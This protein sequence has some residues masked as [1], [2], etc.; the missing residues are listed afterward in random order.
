MRRSVLLTTFDFFSKPPAT[1][2]AFVLKVRHG[3]CL[4]VIPRR[5]E[6]GFVTHVG[7]VRAGEPW[8]QGG[9]TFAEMLHG[10]VEGDVRQVHSENLFA[11][12]NVR[13]IDGDLTIEMTRAEQRT[14]QNIRSVRARQDDDAL[15]GAETV[16]LDEELIQR[17]FCGFVAIG[18]PASTALTTD[19]VDLIDEYDGWFLLTR[20][21]KQIAHARRT[22]ADEHLHEIGTGDGEKRNASF[23][24]RRL[25]EQ[26]LPGS[27]RSDEEGA[28][29]N[30]RTKRLVLFGILQKSPQTP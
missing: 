23:A 10:S 4:H 26:R 2:S 9:E 20:L 12:L 13:T 27:R 18:E 5:R 21:G 15:L 19:G 8:G 17:V 7:D 22:D 29:R 16:H 11:T 25:G 24:S 28:V 14:I 30:L 6:R 1:R 3:D